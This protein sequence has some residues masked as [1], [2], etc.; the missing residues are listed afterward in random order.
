MIDGWRQ[1][2]TLAAQTDDF[3]VM[4]KVGRVFT[5]PEII[6]KEIARFPDID[7]ELYLGWRKDLEE[8]FRHINF[9]A[10]FNEF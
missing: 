7:A 6:A 4:S 1:A 2:L 3:L 10:T 5:V 9:Q 8:A